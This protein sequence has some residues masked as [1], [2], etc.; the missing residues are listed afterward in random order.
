MSVRLFE[1]LH[2]SRKFA[3]VHN[4][5]SNVACKL[6]RLV[7]SVVGWLVGWLVSRGQAAGRSSIVVVVVFQYCVVYN[8]DVIAAGYSDSIVRI[9]GH[10]GEYVIDCLILHSTSGI[11]TVTTIAITIMITRL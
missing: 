1:L 2:A 11:I 3:C 10:D 6:V 7:R 5:Y 8:A 4:Y 9:W